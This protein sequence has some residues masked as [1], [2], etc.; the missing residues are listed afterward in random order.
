MIALQLVLQK[1][2]SIKKRLSLVLWACSLVTIYARSSMN[3]WSV[4]FC[5]LIKIKK[6]VKL[7]FNDLKRHVRSTQDQ[8]IENGM[9]PIR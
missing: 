6:N 8:Q 5:D 3:S 9:L 4:C 1:S 2:F 7:I